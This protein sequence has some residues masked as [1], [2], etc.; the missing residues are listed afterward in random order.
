M[1]QPTNN[2]KITFRWQ[3]TDIHMDGWAEDWSEI[4]KKALRTAGAN[5]YSIVSIERVYA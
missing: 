1:Q 5:H 3:D 4:I 2:Y